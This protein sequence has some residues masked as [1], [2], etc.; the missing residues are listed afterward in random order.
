MPSHGVFRCVFTFAGAAWYTM[1]EGDSGGGGFDAVDTAEAVTDYY[2]LLGVG[3]DA[4]GAE[5]RDAYREA[6]KQIHPD[7]SDLPER[8]AAE[9]FRQ[10]R[11]ARDVLA[12]P[13]ARR[14]Y[15]ELGHEAYREQVTPHGN[16]VEPAGKQGDG[17]RS[18]PDSGSSDS[19]T[20]DGEEPPV[21]PATEGAGGDER[22]VGRE[23]YRA[24]LAGSG[25]G[26]TSLEVVVT[27][28]QAGWR[29]RLLAGFGSAVLVA[30]GGVVAHGALGAA[31]VD[32][33]VSAPGPAVLYGLALLV[34][35]VA[36]ARTCLVVECSLPA[37]AFVADRELGRFSARRVRWLVQSGALA[38]VA[39]LGV[40]ALGARVGVDPW[41]RAAALSRGETDGFAW[42]E[43][44]D[45]LAPWALALDVL[46]TGAF[47]LA[48]LGGVLALAVGTSAALWRARYERGLSVR[49]S[50]W[51]LPLVAAVVTVPFAFGAGTT[52]LLEVPGTGLLPAEL[53]AAFGLETGSVTV[54]TVAM[55]G[56]VLVPGIAGLAAVRLAL[57]ARTREESSGRFPT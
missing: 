5:I 12:D 21:P 24:V 30:V 13:R 40:V 57:A 2:E 6:A 33:G 22:R 48:A 35:L 20:R 55:V 17:G 50:Y 49:P 14:R 3:R 46:V 28:W 37:G 10:V 7:A 16:P 52:P 53:A 44:P 34:A 23:L 8:A 15:D 38:S 56:T 41:A 45:A 11:E 1:G 9:R 27:R 32:A 4:S 39:A 47:A 42:F 36:T 54:A 18:D 43:L 51:E 31:G 19:G 26:N 29:L 25:F